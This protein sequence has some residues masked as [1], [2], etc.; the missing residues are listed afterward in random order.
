MI[1]YVYTVFLGFIIALFIGLGINTFYNAPTAPLYPTE[2]SAV[3]QDEPTAEQI[4]KQNQYEADY[5]TYQDD[6]Q[7]YSRNVSIIAMIS[8]V[9][10]LAIGLTVER[11]RLVNS[12][13]ANGVV[14]SSVF[15]LIYSIIRGFISTDTKFTFIVVTVSVAVSLYLGYHTFANL[16][17]A[18]HKS[19]K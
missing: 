4:A 8:A 10:L 11:M 6:Y 16:L 7:T 9:I 17:P 12:A 15:T 5:Q 18:E 3:K 14:L 1:K 2:T 13:I 19:K